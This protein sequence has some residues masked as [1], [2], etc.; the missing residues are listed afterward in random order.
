MPKFRITAPDGKNFDVEGPEGST[1]EQA[2]A[3][4]QAQ[5]KTS[6]PE[7]GPM[8]VNSGMASFLAS[9]A[10][11]PIDIAQGIYNAPKMIYGLAKGA[12]GGTDLPGT[13]TG[14]AGGSESKRRALN[15]AGHITR[16]RRFTTVK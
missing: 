9:A 13:V 4:V 2:L 8:P 1:A 15:I 12:L 10:G 14:T 5:Y 6:S 16:Q 11:A 7:P 3:Q